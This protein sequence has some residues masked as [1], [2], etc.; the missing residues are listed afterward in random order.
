MGA[1]DSASPHGAAPSG[2][3]AALP[4]NWTR[5]LGVPEF[6]APRSSATAGRVE[7]V[8]VPLETPEAGT[9]ITVSS[10]SS[11]VWTGPS[12]PSELTTGEV[13][14]KNDLR[15]RST[16]PAAAVPS[17]TEWRAGFIVLSAAMK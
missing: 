3:V 4:E 14:V 15:K 5:A 8:D 11:N 13:S 12:W 6:G 10:L 7:G 2:G 1:S 16:V 17:I 9:S